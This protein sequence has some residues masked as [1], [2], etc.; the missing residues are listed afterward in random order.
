MPLA[1]VIFNRNQTGIGRPLPNNDYISSM[2]FYHD[3]LPSGFSA[4]DRIKPIYSLGDAENLG[5]LDTFTDETKASTGG[6]VLST[7]A[8]TADDIEKIIFDGATLGSYT[9]ITGDAVG[10]VATGLAA[11][12]NALTVQH[13]W[14]ATISTATVTLIPPT[15]YGAVS[16]GILSYTSSGTTG[17]ATVVQ[18]TGGVGS[19]QSVMHYHISE[20]FRLQPDGKLFLAIYA[21]NTYDGAEVQ[22]VQEYAEGSIRQFAVFLSHETFATSHV[23]ATQT[24]L[25]T[26]E[27]NDMPCSAIIHVDFTGLALASLSDLSALTAER[28][29]VVIGEDGN[30]HQVAYSNTKSYLIGDKISYANKTYICRSPSTGNAPFDTSKWSVIST[31]IAAIS[32]F[33]IST[34]GTTLGAVSLASVHENIGWVQ[35]FNLASGNILDVPAFVTG[36]LYKAVSDSLRSTLNDSHYIFI[37]SFIGIYGTFHQD[38]WTAIAITNDFAKIEASRVMDKAVRNIRTA[39]IPSIKAPIYVDSDGKLS[40]STI[41]IFKNK[42]DKEL[43]TLATDLEISAGATTINPDQDVLTTEQIVLAVTIVPVGSANEIVINIGFKPNLI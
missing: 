10:D 21:E 2:I 39:M 18:L 12:V 11:A 15:G 41:A 1:D 23:T 13:G 24:V 6:T 33:T 42:S 25:D 32:G 14:T 36:D 3:T 38:S 4:S 35:K 8:G 17:T 37:R 28:V 31:N 5:I 27:T 16:Q 43:D 40:G 30:W 22:T 7:V 19:Y 29:S 34:L 20:Y 26:L 9:V